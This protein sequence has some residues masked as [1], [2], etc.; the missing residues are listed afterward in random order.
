LIYPIEQQVELIKN[1]G[2][3]IGEVVQV[4]RSALESEHLSPKLFIDHGDDVNVVTGYLCTKPRNK[5]P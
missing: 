2:L 3:E 1:S 5:N 4:P